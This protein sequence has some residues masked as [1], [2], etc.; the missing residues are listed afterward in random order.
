MKEKIEKLLAY[1]ETKPYVGCGNS[2]HA[3]TIDGEFF[4]G[5][6]DCAKRLQPILSEFKDKVVVDFGCNIGG[7]LHTLAP[8]IKQGVG[9][10]YNRKFINTA[11]AISRVNNT[12]QLDF[13]VFDFEK[14]DLQQIP[15]LLFSKVDICMI[16]SVARW[17]HKWRELIQVAHSLADTLVYESN[18]SNQAEQVKFLETLY[19][20]KL[21]ASRSDDDPRQSRRM[22]Y[23][24][25]K[26]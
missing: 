12:P 13:Y 16:L 8:E 19:D 23:L 2:Y 10:D 15:D 5:Q 11:T 17:I 4:P 25:K 9:F 7:M 3:I 1:A 6:R 22:L 26:K 20:I 21:I 14:D 24:C 18:G